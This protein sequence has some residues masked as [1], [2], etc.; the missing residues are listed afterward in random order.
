MRQLMLVEEFKNCVPER[1]VV[2]LNEQKVTTLQQAAMLADEFD[3]THRPVFFRRDPL[4]HDSYQKDADTQSVRGNVSMSGSRVEKPCFYCHKP[5]HLI[6]EC[7]SWKQKQQGSGSALKQPKGVG[8]IKTVLPSSQST[9]QKAPDDCF[10]PFIFDGF[11]SLTGQVEVQCPLKVLRDTGGSQSFILAGVL[12]FGPESACEV[13]TVVRGIEMGFV[14]APL[15]RVHV[16]SK[17]VTV[18]FP[19]AVRSCFPIDGVSLSWG[20][21]LQEIKLIRPPRLLMCP[22]LTLS[23]M[24]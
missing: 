7:F 1:T 4:H 5:G 23:V 13:S 20:M 8:L 11:V 12:P 14:P 15:N 18:F 19:V 2:Y 21:I 16:Q 22:F 10:K 6:A 3:L 24:S 9:V 17:L